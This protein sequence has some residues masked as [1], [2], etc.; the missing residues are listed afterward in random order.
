MK[1]L[2]FLFSLLVCVLASA[3]QGTYYVKSTTLNLR[4]EPSTDSKVIHKLS[5][6]Q[7]VQVVEVE[8]DWALVEFGEYKGYVSTTYLSDTK[9]NQAHSQKKELAVLICNSRSAYA[10][11]SHQCHGLKRC[12][13]DIYEVTVSEAIQRGYSPCKICY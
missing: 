6:G 11:H 7:E 9:V 10:Y 12:R 8:G 5:K 2:L 4:S 1:K 3:Q 13:S